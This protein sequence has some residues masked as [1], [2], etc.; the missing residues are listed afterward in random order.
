MLFDLTQDMGEVHDIAP[1][2]PE[3]HRR[4]DDDMM[5]YFHKVGG[6]GRE[7]LPPSIIPPSS[8]ILP[9]RLRRSVALP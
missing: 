3:E 2:H 7:R 6:Q 1:A 4:L 5:G 9:L 8:F